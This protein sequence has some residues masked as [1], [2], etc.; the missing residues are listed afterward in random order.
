MDKPFREALGALTPTVDILTRSGGDGRERSLFKGVPNDAEGELFLALLKKYAPRIN[1]WRRGRGNRAELATEHG[2]TARGFDQ[3]LPVALSTHFSIYPTNLEEVYHT[4]EF[5]APAL[6]R[7]VALQRSQIETLRSEIEEL[8]VG[9]D[10]Y[11]ANWNT[12]KETYETEVHDLQ[13]EIET[14]RKD[15]RTAE[16]LISFPDDTETPEATNRHPAVVVRIEITN[17]EG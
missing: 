4:W 2:H 7:E 11:R 16:S 14:L 9:N 12:M 6:R 15:L 13:K 5:I 10:L 3:D 8:E 1:W 17:Q